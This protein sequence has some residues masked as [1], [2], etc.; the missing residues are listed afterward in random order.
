MTRVLIV[1]DEPQILRA[2]RINLLARQYSQA[3]PWRLLVPDFVMT[4]I[5]PPSAP[6]NAEESA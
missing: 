6:P 3:A 1:D 4:L 5:M 2:L